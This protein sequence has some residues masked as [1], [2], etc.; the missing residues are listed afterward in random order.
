MPMVALCPDRWIFLNSAPTVVLYLFDVL[1]SDLANGLDDSMIWL[2]SDDGHLDLSDWLAEND[3]TD[4]A[5]DGNSDG[6]LNELDSFLTATLSAGNY[7]L[8]IGTGGDFGGADMID[9]LQLESSPFSSG[10]PVAS[11]SSLSYQ[12]TINGDFKQPQSI[13]EPS[14]WVLLTLGFMAMQWGRRKV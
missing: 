1:A 8:A 4:F 2:F 13:P 5:T 14:L 6:S 7:L 9:G 11:S 12:L 10:N 3:D